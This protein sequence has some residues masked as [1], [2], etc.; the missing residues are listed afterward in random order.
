MRRR[1]FLQQTMAAAGTL[2]LAAAVEDSAAMQSSRTHV[3]KL[4]YGPHIGMF[5]HSA[6]QDPIDQ[7][8][9]MADS[10]FQAFEDNG[11]MRRPVDL[12]QHIGD[13]LEKLGMKMGVF[14][15]DTGENWKPSLAT[16]KPEFRDKFVQTCREAVD[17][18][19][20]CHARW[21]TVVPGY[22]ERTLPIGI[23]TGHVIEA[24][25]AGADVL[26]PHGLAMV[27]EPLSDNPDLFLR[28]SDQ[29]YMICRAV[30]S[31]AC[32]VLFDIYHMQRNEG[33]LIP[34]IDLA[35]NEIAYFQIGDVPGRKEPGTGE[36]NYRN[37]FAHI[38]A[39]AHQDGREFVFGM[40]HGNA[41]P[42]IE[43]ERRLIEAYVRADSF[44]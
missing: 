13:T 3:F 10:G 39:K 5:E 25:R 30:N 2:P 14:V 34:H 27:L 33:H 38:H 18:A 28:T 31:P 36:I 35:W 17:V 42:G 11:M 4:L 9:F 44:E 26:A 40:E 43:G 15:I 1:Q 32:K 16:G 8:R 41:G 21:M 23:Q 7:L 29:A 20:R 12:Q 19:R 37:V 6:G 24:L 22:F